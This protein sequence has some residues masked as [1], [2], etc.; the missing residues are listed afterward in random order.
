MAKQLVGYTL[1]Q[2]LVHQQISQQ[3]RNTIA[4]LQAVIV[5]PQFDLK[6]YDVEAEKRQ[7]G[8]GRYSAG[9]SSSC[10]WPSRPVG[11]IADLDWVKVYADRA[12]MKYFT[13]TNPLNLVAGTRNHLAEDLA[14]KMEK[15]LDMLEDNDDVQQVWH[16]WE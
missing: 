14:L 7:I 6:R 11:G 13:S 10:A 8:V 1:P 15:L 12:Y 3:V 16:N 9:A 2:T 5:G 4:D